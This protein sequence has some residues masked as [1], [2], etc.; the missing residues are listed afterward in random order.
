MNRRRACLRKPRAM[1]PPLLLHGHIGAVGGLLAGLFTA[2]LL[3]WQG[4]VIHGPREL[5]RI[6]PDLWLGTYPRTPRPRPRTQAPASLPARG[7]HDGP[8]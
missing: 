3:E 5:D 8:P 1:I 7:P 4:A 6:A 2:L